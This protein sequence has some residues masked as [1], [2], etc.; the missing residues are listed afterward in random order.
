MVVE[1]HAHDLLRSATLTDRELVEDVQIRGRRRC[2]GRDTHAE[3]GVAMVRPDGR[4]A[5]QHRH[6][7]ALRG[8]DAGHGGARPGK[9]RPRL[10]FLAL[11]HHVEEMRAD[12]SV[13]EPA[14]TP[15][16]RAE[17]LELTEVRRSLDR[18]TGESEPGRSVAV[19]HALVAVVGLVV[20]ELGRQPQRP[21]QLDGCGREQMGRHVGDGTGDGDN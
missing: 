13:R 9:G 6:G 20:E 5:A 14:V 1:S 2:S 3:L 15:Q 10:H 11:D 16:R 18:R 8:R 21:H 4:C 7:V 19:V 17:R 12:A